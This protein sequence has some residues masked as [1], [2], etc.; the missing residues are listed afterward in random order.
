MAAKLMGKGLGGGIVGCCVSEISQ[1]R[2]CRRY[3]GQILMAGRVVACL[4]QRV[5]VQHMKQTAPACWLG[6]QVLQSQQ[7]PDMRQLSDGTLTAWYN[8][9]LRSWAGL[10]VHRQYNTK[11]CGLG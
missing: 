4:G 1:P 7:A 11:V 8:R 2:S 6:Y 10:A 3:K 5:E 9:L